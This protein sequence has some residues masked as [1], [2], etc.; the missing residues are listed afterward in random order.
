MSFHTRSFLPILGIIIIKFDL[1]GDM[2]KE[3]ARIIAK[4]RLFALS[5]LSRKTLSHKLSLSLAKLIQSCDAKTIL[6]YMPLPHEPNLL[7][8]MKQLRAH[9]TRILIPFMEDKS[10]KTVQYR[11]PLATKAF[12]IKEPLKAKKYQGKFDMMVVPIVGFDRSARR[13]GFGKGFYDRFYASLTFQ[14]LVVFVQLVTCFF[15]KKITFN[16][17]IEAT[18]I[19]TPQFSIQREF[20]KNDGNTFNFNSRVRSRRRYRFCNRQT[21]RRT[22]IP[23]LCRT[24]QSQSQ[25]D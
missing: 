20:L 9:N 25:S 14:P 17:D 3:S 7:P 19:I 23:D 4:K 6:F 1:G 8:L 21:S 10:L 5:P 22:Q 11:G 15:S 13:I 24:S 12:G 16:H 18:H 2:D